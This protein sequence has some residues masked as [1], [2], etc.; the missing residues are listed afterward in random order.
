MLPFEFIIDGPPMSAQ[1]RNRGRLAAWKVEV[2]A[3]A[4]RRWSGPLH[5]GKAR[6]IVTYY[7]I[8]ETAGLDADNMIKPILDA[9]IGVV[10]VDDRQATH[11]TARNV[12]L[13][14]GRD[15][16]FGEL[17]GLEFSRGRDFLH[18]LIEEDP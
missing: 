15:R 3:A 8:R 10:Y 2:A 16:N 6:V 5:H 18:V 4:A 13:V 11:I 14:D 17:V 9:L 12:R 7:H 1:S